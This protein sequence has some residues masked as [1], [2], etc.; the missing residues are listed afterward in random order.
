MKV[1][2][3]NSSQGKDKPDR[4]TMPA[5]QPLEEEFGKRSHG[6]SGPIWV[7]VIKGEV[8]THVYFSLLSGHT[9][10]N[11]RIR[12]YSGVRDESLAQDSGRQASFYF[13]YFVRLRHGVRCL[14]KRDSQP[15]NHRRRSYVH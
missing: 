8:L 10:F 9:R 5:E 14:A 13:L 7:P 4:S 1:V 3:S 11:S 6:A 15:A 2:P 12:D